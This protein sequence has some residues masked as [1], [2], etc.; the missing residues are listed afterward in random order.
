MERYKGTNVNCWD[1]LASADSR[2]AI[3][4]TSL[5][6]FR[7]LTGIV[8]CAM[9][10]SWPVLAQS[11]QGAG[12]PAGNT[13]AA[14]STDIKTS[15]AERF[16]E[17][18]WFDSLSGTVVD[19]TGMPVAGAKVKL[20]REGD[21]GEQEAI[22]NEDGKFAF[23]NI[24]PG[25]FQLTITSDGFTTH[26]SSGVLQLGEVQVLPPITL[27]VATVVSE[28]RVGLTPIE[29]A[30]E[31]LHEEEQ[32]RVFGFVP[33]YYVTYVPNAA[34]L[35]SK[36]KFNLAWKTTIDPVSF[37]LNAG[38]A[39]IEQAANQFSGYGQGA[40][41]YAKRY[42]A[43]Y[44]DFAIGTFIGG[45]V[46]PSLLKQDPR[47]FYKG[48]GSVHSRVMYA[49]ANAVICKGDNGRWQPNY[50]SIMGSIA[51]GGISNLY[52]PASDR[53]S[54]LIFENT[55][56]GIG[57]TAAA[58]LLQEFVIRRLTPNLPNHAPASP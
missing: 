7:F 9:A 43:S 55:L 10:W 5:L 44:A 35:N 3:R 51:A 25:P 34:P 21:T 45:A 22:C 39:G 53:G 2:A 14:N 1:T 42:G 48:T 32:Q 19:P 16:P 46:L 12:D 40:Q 41:G 20:T 52:Y 24:A 49:I 38:S 15:G 17:H 30:Q 54:T 29:L 13:G 36:Q 28:V 33:N 50:S 57:T 58:N 31:Q 27:T 23:T 47:Y 11:A 37:A 26:A 56:I 18:N 6:S 4:R 8:V